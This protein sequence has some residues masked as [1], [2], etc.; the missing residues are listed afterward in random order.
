MVQL[1]LGKVVGLLLSEPLVITSLFAVVKGFRIVIS[2]LSF[3][4]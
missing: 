3:K 2:V 4:E 1:A